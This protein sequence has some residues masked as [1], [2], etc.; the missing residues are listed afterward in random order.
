MA[1]QVIAGVWP[2]S[3]HQLSLVA[4]DNSP[5]YTHAYTHICKSAV[6]AFSFSYS[7]FFLHV[8]YIRLFE[9]SLFLFYN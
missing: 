5:M 4:E 8:I 1:D 3:M 9:F 7:Y 2:S 6:I